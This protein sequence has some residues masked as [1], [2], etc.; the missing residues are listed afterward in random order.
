[1]SAISVK[2]SELSHF[3]NIN[4]HSKELKNLE[5]Q[6]I[7]VYFHDITYQIKQYYEKIK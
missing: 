6:K 2:L 1:M 7:R 5:K 3:R 4:A